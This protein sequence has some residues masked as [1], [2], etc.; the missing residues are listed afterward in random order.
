M[1]NK[2]DSKKEIVIQIKDF[3]TSESDTGSAETQTARLTKRINELISHF[4]VH[5][6][7]F[8]SRMGLIHKINQ[9]KRLLNYLKKNN[10]ESYQSVVHRLNLR[11]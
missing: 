1:E 10:F 3:Q 7:D 8:H 6:K 5:K 9:R 11:K 2:K 4:K